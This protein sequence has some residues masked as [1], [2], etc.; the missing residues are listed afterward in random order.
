[1]LIRIVR[2]PVTPSLLPEFMNGFNQSK[3][4]IR[5]FDG[6][7][8]LEL[9]HDTNEKNVVFTYSKWKSASHLEVYMQS[10]LFKLTWQKVRPL[11]YEKP[12]AWSLNEIMTL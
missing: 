2:L 1:M 7:T 6:C 3:E 5:N 9:L 11:F 10:E 12:Q 8:H 4:K